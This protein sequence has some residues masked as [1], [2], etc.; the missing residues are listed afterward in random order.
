MTF[1]HFV[2][3]LFKFLSGLDNSFKGGMMYR[4]LISS[5]ILFLIFN[6]Q[7]IL[8][9]ASV[10]PDS[11]L[12]KI[13]LSHK[14]TKLSL[15]DA[16]QSALEN[17]TSVEA[18][19]AQYLA[20]VA[21]VR[22]ESGFFD[23]EFFFSYNYVD[24]KMPAAS[25]FAGANT[26]S[27]QQTDYKTGLRLNL[28]IGTQLELSM[29][30]SKLNTNSTFAFLNPEYDT[31]GAISFR[32]P[33]LEGFSATARERLSMAENLLEGKKYFYNQQMLAINTS[34]ERVYWD[35]YALERNYAVQELTR[36]EA[37]ALLQEAELRS[38]SGLVGPN[39]VANA[40]TFLAQQE[41]LLLDSE[42][43][44]DKQSDQFAALIGKKPGGG[45]TRF[46][47]TDE[48]S[49]DYYVENADLLV[50]YTLNSNLDLQAAKKNVESINIQVSSAKWKVL[51]SLDLFG[52]LGGNGLTGTPQDVVFGDQTFRTTRSGSFGDA[53]TQ[54]TKR[55]FP[56]W[57]I[58]VELTLPV[59]F[60]SNSAEKERL[61]AEG[62]NAQQIYIE[63]SRSL[64]EQVRSA[65][66]ELSHGKKRID[67][68]LEGVKAA[69][70][71]VR[72]GMIEFHNGKSTAFELVRLGADFA[73]AQQR[74][75]EALVRTAKAAALL[76]QLTS[77]KYTGRN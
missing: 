2:L 76:K 75:S 23:P 12:Q 47:P 56:N 55:E 28:P 30:A 19:E 62:I 24:Q 48:P 71:Q 77:G 20:A 60:R 44:L 59:G 39:Q 49:S 54:L 3:V 53:I 37:K 40:K 65:W 43:Q 10:N 13:L 58:G 41:L 31:Y 14:G 50:D 63:L 7:G 22:R 9:Q 52:S 61:E 66:R 46:I 72:I 32:Q 4:E 21:T 29:N 5:F 68:A 6:S 73:T 36:D 64:E 25:F 15:A 8:A 17:A 1:G 35:L 38:K 34:V 16:K 74:Y 33:L 67:A 45:T 57:S 70:E 42:E 11:A 69:Q 26:L 27:T 18:A 51:P